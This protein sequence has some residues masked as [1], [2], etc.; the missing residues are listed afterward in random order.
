MPNQVFI[1]LAFVCF[2]FLLPAERGLDAA[3]YP[4]LDVQYARVAPHLDAGLND[5][6]WDSAVAI[7]HLSLSLGDTSDLTALPTE[8]RLLWDEHFLYIRF[9]CTG[10]DIY[11]PYRGHDQPHYKGD[12]VEVF[13]D[14]VGDA[15]EYVEIELTPKNDTF[16]QVILI[17]A[18]QVKS[19]SQGVLLKEVQERDFWAFPQW[20]LAG[21]RTAAKICVLPS[22]EQGWIAELAIPANPLLQRLGR[23]TFMAMTMH[24]NLLRYEW[25]KSGSDSGAARQLIPMN[26][27]PVRNG[28]PHLSPEAMGLLRLVK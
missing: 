15:R 7:P 17:T 4:T 25:R 11:V 13:L 28:S 6:A 18:P 16:D 2:A 22:G 12:V 9:I 27:A 10:T 20:D 23:T 24:A 1:F 21:L 26:W 8:V 14:P 3:Q 19:D 5:P